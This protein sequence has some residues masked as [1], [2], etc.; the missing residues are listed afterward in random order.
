MIPYP[1][2]KNIDYIEL[3]KHPAF[4]IGELMASLIKIA[5]VRRQWLPEA[6]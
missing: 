2:T 5:G 1:Y 4:S 3:T 6:G